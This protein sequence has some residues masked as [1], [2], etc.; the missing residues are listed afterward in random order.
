MATARRDSNHRGHY[1][2]RNGAASYAPIVGAFGA[3]AVPAI[4][5]LFG[6]P[7]HPHAPTLITLAAGL[8]IVSMIASLIGSIGLAAI[9]AETKTTANIPASVMFV[10]VS[11]VVSA[12]NIL[13]AFEVLAAI[14]LPLSRNLF[15]II[16][17]AGGAIGV[18]FL[19]FAIGDSWHTTPGKHP[20]AVRTE[21]GPQAES[22]GLWIRL[23]SN[24][25]VPGD[26][27]WL[28]SHKQAQRLSDII[29]LAG[30]VPILLG[31]ILR[32]GSV[33]VF[34]K[35]EAVNWIVGAGLAL[36]V[37]GAMWGN[38][39]TIHPTDEPETELRPWEAYGSIFSV[40]L[41]TLI[42]LIFMP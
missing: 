31:I 6:L 15:A 35:L 27:P 28:T 26:K 19:G 36:A 20:S 3:L 9:G 11:V 16:A 13:A 1:D 4:I 30:V 32:L 12:V 21:G 40:S 39:R 23:W 14:Y 2:I 17:G 37:V 5:L 8:L 24:L 10:G 41:Y 33:T 22:H 34:P 25:W 18:F 38:Y 7:R 29:G 42:L